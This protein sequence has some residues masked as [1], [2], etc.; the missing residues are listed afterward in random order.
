MRRR[1][2]TRGAG[3]ESGQSLA[4]RVHD[5][6]DADQADEGTGDVPSV[7]P[8]SVE[9]HAPGEGSGDKNAVG[10]EDAAEVCVGLPSGNEAVDAECDDTC[11]IQIQPRCSRTLCQISH[12]PPISATAATTNSRI[13]RVTVMAPTLRDAHVSVAHVNG[14]GEAASAAT[15]DGGYPVV[16]SVE[17]IDVGFWNA[18][19][20]HQA[21]LSRA[22][23]KVEEGAAGGFAFGEAACE[24]LTLG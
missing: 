21:V 8:E 5:Y 24:R 4:R 11:A 6:G 12:A 10:G 20:H 3:L 14:D 13:E 9:G 17:D 22:D 15:S 18:D 23:I 2:G 1:T 7:W 16:E 19:P